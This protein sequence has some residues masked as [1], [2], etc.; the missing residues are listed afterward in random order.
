MAEQVTNT[1]SL[2]NEN[3]TGPVSALAA[4]PGGGGGGNLG[5]PD[6]N[7]G[8]DLFSKDLVN[9]FVSPHF[10]NEGTVGSYKIFICNNSGSKDIFTSFQN[11]YRIE[12][13][14]TANE[15]PNGFLPTSF[16][17][18]IDVE[19]KIGHL[20]PIVKKIKISEYDEFVTFTF[21]YQPTD[22]DLRKS[23]GKTMWLRKLTP[24]ILKI[25]N[26]RVTTLSVKYD[27]LLNNTLFE[28]Q[29]ITTPYF[30][31]PTLS[32]GKSIMTTIGNKT[33]GVTSIKY[34]NGQFKRGV[35]KTGVWNDGWRSTWDG[36]DDIYYFESIN[37]NTFQLSPNMWMLKI[38]SNTNPNNTLNI[39]DNLFVN[40]FISLSNVVGI[41]LN[42]ERYLLKDYYRISNIDVSGAIITL[43]IEI[44]IA[45]FPLRR[46]EVDS[47]IHLIYVTKNIWL[48]G[49]FLNGYFRGIWNYGL[50]K[51]FPFTT[52]MKDSHFVDGKFDGGRFISGTSSIVSSTSVTR[53]YHTGLIQFF[54]F[55]DNNISETEGFSNFID[56]TYQS[57][58]DVNYYTQSFV[59]LNSLTSIYDENF[60]KK[61]PIPN[62]YGYPTLDVLS[63]TS[64]F[65]NTN[66]SDVDYYNLGTKYKIFTDYLGDNGYFRKAFNSEGKPGLDDFIG[67]GWTANSGAFYGT[68]TVSFVYNSNIT[69]RNVNRIS[70][71]MA[72]FGYNV[73]NNN[74]IRLDDKKYTIVEYDMEY[75]QRGYDANTGEYTNSFSK[76]LNL[77][78]SNYPSTTNIFKSGLLKT[79][80]F[81][82]KNALDLILRYNSEYTP[83][84]ESL[85]MFGFNFTYSDS[86][87]ETNPSYSTTYSFVMPQTS[88]AFSGEDTVPE[89]I[90]D[91]AYNKYDVVRRAT[92]DAFGPYFISLS[93][94]NRSDLTVA[95]AWAR[96]VVGF[97]NPIKESA[98]SEQS[99]IFDFFTSVRINYF[100]FLEVDSLPFFKYW[101]FEL[102]FDKTFK[103]G[104]RLG[105]EFGKPHG[106]KSGDIISLKLDETKFNPDYEQENISIV[107]V[108][109]GPL[110]SR[111]R[112]GD[113]AY[114][115]KLSIPY[116][117]TVSFL[118]ESGTIKK[119]GDR[120]D[121]RIQTNYYASAPK[122]DGLDEN[123]VYLGNN[124]IFVDRNS[125]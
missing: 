59:N 107:S 114:T 113:V 60:G 43:T 33:G 38:D 49:T 37:I 10:F 91:F 35:W 80:Y 119:Q 73:L 40:D 112:A 103:D 68:P 29:M 50:F 74:N 5:S 12:V 23:G 75:F 118:S 104:T 93:E 115:V 58:I 6:W 67:S 19:F 25:V 116:G 86:S 65:K 34:G 62:L 54:E 21:F 8:T 61:V 83:P 84:V 20:N 24:G 78:G 70:I 1:G 100:K 92:G 109:D 94:N 30:H 36:S 26:S 9:T 110:R 16:G 101:D 42:E 99:E 106:L 27:E 77:L 57:W 124:Q 52:V 18:F 69:R 14:L 17:G 95:T 102:N 76:P 66:D 98:I 125:F 47:S 4:A 96:T 11:G 81:F 105:L 53:F 2:G 41:D 88:T 22:F 39:I 72:T 111:G 64:K 44:P 71:I 48:G 32:D 13:T 31:I 56:N 85:G 90:E 117:N 108:Q 3:L 120:I 55:Y 7:L 46:F 89:Y 51:G 97:N 87:G 45:K 63:S 82:N 28:D 121:K 122:V 123:F 15:F 79:E